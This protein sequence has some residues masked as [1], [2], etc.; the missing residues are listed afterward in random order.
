MEAER[1]LG[2][3]FLENAVNTKVKLK[4]P[5]VTINIDIKDDKYYTILNKY[6]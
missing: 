4:D 3:L 2:G 1:Y 6:D 5:D